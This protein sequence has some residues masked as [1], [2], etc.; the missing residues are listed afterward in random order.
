MAVYI[1]QLSDWPAFYW[2]KGLISSMV[3]EIHIDQARL[4]GKMESLGFG[5]RNESNLQILTLDVLKSSEIEG[6]L[7]ERDEVRS[8]VARKLGLDIAGLVK[9]DRYVDGVVEMMLEATQNFMEAISKER[10]FKWHSC[11]FQGVINDN[12]KIVIG[13]WRNNALHDPMQVISGPFERRIIHFQA[14]GSHLIQSEME[15]FMY[16]FNNNDS[17]DPFLKAAITHLWFITIHP[18]DDGNGRIARTLTDMQ[19]CRADNNAQRFYSMSAQ[20]RKQR[21]N[22]YAVLEKTQKGDLDITEWLVW[23]L[24]CLSEALKQT[25]I[26]LA[27][28]FTKA[29][30]WDNNSGK[31]FN[32]RQILMINK[33]LDGFTGKLNSSKWATITKCSQD[34]ALRDIQDLMRKK[35]LMKE[36][37][38]GRSTSYRVIEN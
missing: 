8:S 15:S 22:Y 2:N 32:E 35:V 31:I 26:L 9:T 30:F 19:L 21:K 4:L 29:K 36:E 28:V 16:W 17:V 20:I 12:K 5:L 33:L 14:P 7:F 6:V 37:G 25:E 24:N 34:T 13:D 11:L 23:F 27:T 18:F 3:N 1:H 10:F 38:G